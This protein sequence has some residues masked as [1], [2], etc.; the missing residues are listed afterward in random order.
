M[1]LTDTKNDMEK[2]YILFKCKTTLYDCLRQ[3]RRAVCSDSRAAYVAG[4][5]PELVKGILWAANTDE[6]AEKVMC[7]L[8]NGKKKVVRSGHDIHFEKPRHFLKA[9]K[10]LEKI[11]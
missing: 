9:M 3:F 10:M 2:D 1:N 6:S 11:L 8:S 5:M 4:V 7:L